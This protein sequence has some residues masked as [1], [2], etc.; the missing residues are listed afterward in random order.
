MIRLIRA[1]LA[2]MLLVAGLVWPPAA[3]ADPVSAIAL[4][5]QAV[6]VSGTVA[7]IA[8]IAVTTIAT[9]VAIGAALV[10][11]VMARRKAARAAAAAQRAAA[12][13][14]LQERT[15]V[16]QS[17]EPSPQVIYGRATVGGAVLDRLSSAKTYVGDDGTVKTRP[18][19]LQHIV[20]GLACHEI[21]S[22]N[23]VFMHGEWLEFGADR[24]TTNVNFRKSDS[25]HV[26]T[27]LVFNSA[28]QATIPNVPAGVSVSLIS[29]TSVIWPR[30][31]DGTGT[32][33][34]TGATVS[35]ATISGGP[36]SGLW[37]V[38][39]TLGSAIGRVRMEWFPGTTTQ[40]ASTYLIA[41]NSRWTSAHQLLGIAYVVLTLDLDD[42]RFQSGLPSDLAFDVSG[43]PLYDPRT[44]VTGASSD[45][46][47]LAVYDWLRSPWGY[48]LTTADISTASVIAA[49]N[50]CDVL[51]GTEKFSRVGGS[52]KTS[53]DRA[54]VLADLTENMGG[55]VAQGPLWSVHAGAWAAPVMSITDDDAAAP[56]QVARSATDH[57]EAFNS[58]RATVIPFGGT[59]TED[60]DPYVNAVFVAADGGNEWQSFTLPFCVS[61]TQ[62]RN[63]LRQ[64]VE[65][66]RA[67]MIVQYTGRMRLWRL[68]VG[69]RITLTDSIHQ[70][71]NK[72]FRVLDW[73]WA[74]GQPVSLTLQEDVA[75]T[76]DQADAMD[77]DPAP[78]TSLP[79]PGAVSTPMGVTVTSGNSTL[80]QMSDGTI[81]P[82][83]QVSWTR[84]TGIYMTSAGAW[85]AVEWRHVADATWTTVRAVGDADSVMLDGVQ[86]QSAI[87]VRVR[88]LNSFGV[89][90]A[91]VI[92]SHIVAGKS[93]AP[94]A[95]TALA[96]AETSS[97]VRVLAVT[98]VPDLDHA[99]YDARYS[100]NLTAGWAT[101]T[102]LTRWEGP[103]ATC[104]VSAPAA[105]TWRIAVI[106]VD[107]SGNESAPVYTTVT[108]ADIGADAGG[109]LV[110][111]GYLYGQQTGWSCPVVLITPAG[112]VAWTH[113]LSLT[114]RDTFETGNEFAVRA[115]ELLYVGAD[116]TG[117][118]SAYPIR[119]GIR[120]RSSSGAISY[121]AAVSLPAGT[122]WTRLDGTLTVPADAVT[123]TPWVQIDGPVGGT[124]PQS[125]ASNL[126]ISRS[127]PA[128]QSA[129][130]AANAAAA[131]L[132]ATSALAQLAAI[133]SDG[134]LSAVEKKSAIVDW[135]SLANGQTGIVAQANALGITT[136]RDAYTGALSTLAAYLSAL[137]PGWADTTQST[138]IVPAVW[139]SNWD[140]A[141]QARQNLLNRI[142]AVAATRANYASVSNKPEGGNICWNGDGLYGLAGWES[143]PDFTCDDWGTTNTNYWIATGMSSS[144]FA[145][146]QKRRDMLFGDS[147]GVSKG[148]VY[149]FVANAVRTGGGA[150]GYQSGIGF[151]GYDASGN[152]V[153]YMLA[154]I[155]PTYVAATKLTG[156]V[157]IPGGVVSVR[158][159]LW[160]DGNSDFYTSGHGCHWTDIDIRRASTTEL[161]APNAATEVLE[162]R[163][164][165]PISCSSLSG[166]NKRVLTTPNFSSPVDCSAVITASF[167][168]ISTI[169]GTWT[170]TYGLSAYGSDGVNSSGGDRVIGGDRRRYTTAVAI[171]MKAGVP[172]YAVLNAGY[173]TGAATTTV[174]NAE[175]RVE[176][177]K[178]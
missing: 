136:E 167:D 80:I 42:S 128:V 155:M 41:A 83:A 152:I 49:A 50:A 97:G 35:G 51:Y 89:E 77:P 72:T 166:G 99:G 73:S 171:S 150:G 11:G 16:L 134:I 139:R 64:F 149:S 144:R 154:A 156:Q 121:A 17:S 108:L 69:D 38:S 104:E 151:F 148:E 133:G 177:I 122:G 115:G 103:G 169:N 25:A 28:G 52:F 98:H 39:Y 68:E 3:H 53:E 7:T 15:L 116:I 165:G 112:S 96:V 111:D 120:T 21:T 117:W 67:G 5:A 75:S 102:P 160:V 172:A 62:A 127:M 24:W 76:Y 100:A 85:T 119:F 81:L 92:K 88:H 82:R 4:I 78:N 13:E 45:N 107:T 132:S 34:H 91:W 164:E 159:W 57:D 123:A 30:S 10:G 36:T 47:A 32:A 31:E 173:N 140:N 61:K 71:T 170:T 1:A 46:T 141:Y 95:P 56:V 146:T 174:W 60:V 109:N 163:S 176:I 147:V 93:A 14:S 113:A 101:M 12:R 153:S 33:S 9:Y 86:D 87:L 130:A 105:G 74:P 175:I 125:W 94:T 135:T 44:G 43:K 90:S 65:Q 19:A 84:P 106:A 48:N 18:D 162:V 142:S 114:G 2:L 58:A 129:Q 54:A 138:T 157:T 131:Q 6:A 178:R 37:Q 124:W 22:V 110:H 26:T 118:Q 8:G 158:V 161:L 29:I 143:W 79:P 137:S 27:S 63:L 23:R 126:S 66:A 70:I 145:Y 20:I 168:A 55:F 59:Q 40:A